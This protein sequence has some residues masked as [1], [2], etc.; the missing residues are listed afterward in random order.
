LHFILIADCSGSMSQDGKIQALNNAVREALPHMVRVA[1]DNPN[2]ELLVRALRFSSGAFWHVAAPTPVGQFIWTDLRADGLTD[3][4]KALKMVAE[5]L[6]MP[7]MTD[8][9]LPPVLVLVSDGQPTDDFDEGLTA[10][11]SEPW[12]TKA[13]RIAI[14]I[15]QDA[16]LDVLQRFIGHGE[17]HPLQANNPEALVNL[18]KWASTVVP[19]SV[20]SPASIVKGS[21]VA[22]PNV[23]ALPP[24][25]AI[26]VNVDDVW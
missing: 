7:P 20:S 4:G 22:A 9:A 17:L 6:R 24:P 3:L 1:D 21:P 8:R 11:M 14:A 26:P 19:Q 25:A 2:A 10:L 5:Q 13:V 23:P 12:G 18:I 16:D 15:G